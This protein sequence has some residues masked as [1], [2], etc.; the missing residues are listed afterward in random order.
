MRLLRIAFSGLSLYQ[1][2]L[3]IDFSASQRVQGEAK[4]RLYRI[5]DHIYVNPVIELA[6][7]NASGKTITLK[8]ISF[9][10]EM[11]NGGKINHIAGHGLVQEMITNSPIQL[12]VNF[13]WDGEFYVLKT[14]VGKVKSKANPAETEMAIL[15]EKLYKQDGDIKKGTWSEDPESENSQIYSIFLD[16]NEA[17]MYLSN[18][19]S[20]NVALVN[21]KDNAIKCFD[22]LG[23]VNHNSLITFGDYLPEIIHFLDPSI[24]SFRMETNDQQKNVRWKLKFKNRPDELILNS[25]NEIEYYLSSGTIKGISI[26]MLSMMTFIYGGYIL[27][28]ELENHFNRKIVDSLLEFFLS[29][30]I[31]KSGGTIIFST[32]YPELLDI[33]ERNDAIY[34][35]SHEDKISCTNLSSLKIRSDGRKTS[36]FYVQNLLGRPTAPS[37]KAYMDLKGALD[38]IQ[39]ARIEDRS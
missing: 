28:D 26:F 20:I 23:A 31:N 33:P 9:V 1:D 2:D 14:T 25:I 19:I 34:I 17:G 30:R 16:R 37:Y 24:E 36:K 6:G 22:C 7:L 21:Q 10:M 27:V 39:A 18:D 32:H 11:M 4:Y 35:L 8:M 12:T 13:Y 38:N 5:Q 3:V 15:S 29:P